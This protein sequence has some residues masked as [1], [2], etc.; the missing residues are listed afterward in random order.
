[1]RVISISDEALIRC[2]LT[3]LAQFTNAVYEQEDDI[4]LVTLL[5]M[6]TLAII[7]HK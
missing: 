4:T 1:M 3:E 5:L 2:L 7:N 6:N